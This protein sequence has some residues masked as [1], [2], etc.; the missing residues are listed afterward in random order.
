ML[1]LVILCRFG[2]L[3]TWL[4]NLSSLHHHTTVR[5]IREQ[6]RN[7]MEDFIAAIL[8]FRNLIATLYKDKHL[9]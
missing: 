3:W 9:A 7:I 8:A 2:H 5:Y 4:A 6:K 1:V